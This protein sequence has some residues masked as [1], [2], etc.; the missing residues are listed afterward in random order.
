M[1]FR[2]IR[3]PLELG[4]ECHSVLVVVVVVF[5]VVGFFG[6]L[7]LAEF[8]GGGGPRELDFGAWGGRLS[9]E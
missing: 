3:F 8:D 2:P 1:S 9:Y 7:R 5:V 6:W 4:R